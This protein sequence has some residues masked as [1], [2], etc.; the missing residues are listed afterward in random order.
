MHN[1]TLHVWTRYLLQKKCYWQ[2]IAT[3]HMDKDTKENPPE[4][5]NQGR[6]SP[7]SDKIQ[8]SSLGKMAFDCHCK[9]GG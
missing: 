4:T 8:D 1:V 5:K 6:G 2:D 9:I 7:Y 3:Q